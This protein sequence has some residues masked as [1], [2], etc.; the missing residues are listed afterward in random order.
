MT[1]QIRALLYFIFI[2]TS[3]KV[4]LKASCCQTDFSPNQ[5]LPENIDNLF[6]LC[7]G[8]TFDHMLG[9]EIDH[10][11]SMFISENR[12]KCGTQNECL[13][14]LFFYNPNKFFCNS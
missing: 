3:N 2:L 12:S 13:H 11:S 6:L 9:D 10:V 7:Q 4:P 5:L 1:T 14:I 8:Q